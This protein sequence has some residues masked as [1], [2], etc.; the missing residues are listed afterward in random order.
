MR[1]HRIIQALQDCGPMT[2]RSIAEAAKVDYVETCKIIT[3][4]RARGDAPHI[5]FCGKIR[6][7]P[8]R[9]SKVYEISDAADA[10][11]SL[12]LPSLDVEEEDRCNREDFLHKLAAKIQPFRDPMVF[13]TA[14]RAP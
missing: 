8:T 14:G 6:G 3:A 11:E 9:L 5:R 13:L 1:I 10:D 7:G 2:S 12:I 4:H